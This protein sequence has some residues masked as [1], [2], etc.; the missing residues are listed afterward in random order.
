MDAP[1]DSNRSQRP[2]SPVENGEPSLESIRRI[3]L[4][5]EAERINQLEEEKT[6]LEADIAGLQAR[7]IALQAELAAAEG[8]DRKSVV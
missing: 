7:L 6:R 1:A 2:T 8:Q 4:A 3:L 5:R